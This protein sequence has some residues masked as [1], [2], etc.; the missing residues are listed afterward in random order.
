[1]TGYSVQA[2][3]FSG[4]PVCSGAFSESLQSVSTVYFDALDTLSLSQSCSTLGLDTEVN[5]AYPVLPPPR[6]FISYLF[7]TGGWKSCTRAQVNTL[8]VPHSF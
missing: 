5:Y 2:D 4:K 8:F 7:L 6:A 1:M 3:C